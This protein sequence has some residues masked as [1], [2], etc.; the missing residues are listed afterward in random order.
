MTYIHELPNWPTFTWDAQAL[1]ETL[2]AVRHKQGKHLGRMEAL[3]FDLRTE[4]A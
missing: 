3:G 2:S 4:A 1:A